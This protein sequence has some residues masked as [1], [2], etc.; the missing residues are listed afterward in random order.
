MIKPVSCGRWAL[1]YVGIV[2]ALAVLRD[3]GQPIAGSMDEGIA[4]VSHEWMPADEPYLCTNCFER[5][6]SWQYALEHVGLTNKEE[7]SWNGK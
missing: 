1:H 7:L 2:T 4:K 3:D 5:F 6:D